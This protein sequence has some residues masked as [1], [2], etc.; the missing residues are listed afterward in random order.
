MRT[1][2]A[3]AGMRFRSRQTHPPQQPETRMSRSLH[4]LPLSIAFLL[5]ACSPDA[6]PPAAQTA[7]P[8]PAAQPAE[9]SADTQFADLSKRWLDGSFKISP[10]SAT[11][12]GDHRFDGE[13]DD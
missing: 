11:S 9:P 12:V 13:L 6:P 2:P 5:T 3:C 4:V 7:A 1:I 8:A 10:V